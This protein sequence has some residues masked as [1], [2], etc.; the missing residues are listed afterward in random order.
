MPKDF[1]DKVR[2]D[3]KAIEQQELP[4]LMAKGRRVQRRHDLLI[5]AVAALKAERQAQGVSLGQLEKRTGISKS[6]LS[7]L[8]NDPNP[9]PTVTT[10]LRIAEAL[11]RQLTIS[12]SDPREAA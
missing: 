6:V 1:R 2:R 5:H 10:L 9:N 3:V 12:I 8:E 11:G 7:R 4:E